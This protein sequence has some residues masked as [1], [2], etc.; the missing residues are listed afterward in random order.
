M[1]QWKRLVLRVPEAKRRGR[2]FLLWRGGGLG[3][4]IRGRPLRFWMG[5]VLGGWMRGLPGPGPLLEWRLMV[6]DPGGRPRGRPGN[7]V[8]RFGGFSGS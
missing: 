3:G 6:M 7:L 5:V 2:P 8:G 4:W 1:D